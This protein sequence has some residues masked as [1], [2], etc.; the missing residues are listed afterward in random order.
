MDTLYKYPRTPHLPFSEGS[1]SDDKYVSQD[2]VEFLKSGIELVVTEKMD[3]GN[4]TFYR[5]N[6]H[7]RS[8]TSKTHSW[9]TPV[10]S[11][12]AEKRFDIPEG[13]RISGESVYAQ[14]SVA[15]TGLE[16]PFL[17]FGI[18]DDNNNLLSW[19]ETVEWSNLLELSV[20]PV[21]Y[22]GNDYNKAIKAWSE[23]LDEN[24]SEGFVVRSANSFHYDDFAQNI[25]K[26][27]RK[28]HVQTSDGF[29][30]RDDF[31]VNGFK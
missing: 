26:F 25:A 31:K 8:L 9:D 23:K 29:R 20:V 30:S 27:V 15:Y 7:A 17:V 10:K 14:R 4:I 24:V 11:L 16:S 6:F 2:V 21:L 13:W 3:G 28:D 12:W 22:R 1:T 18:W 5:D 19:S